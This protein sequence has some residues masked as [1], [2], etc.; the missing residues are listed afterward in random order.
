VLTTVL[1]WLIAVGGALTSVVSF[2]AL[3][4]ILVGKDGA[5]NS[6][7]AG[8]FLVVAVPPLT[9]IAG[10]GLA[11]RWRWAWYG[12]VAGLAGVMLWNAAAMVSHPAP[13][14]TTTVSASGTKT[15]VYREGATFFLPTFVLATGLLVVL[16]IPRVRREFTTARRPSSQATGMPESATHTGFPPGDESAVARGWRVGHEGRDQMYYEERHGGGWQRIDISGEMLMGRA[17]HVIYFPSAKAWERMPEWARLRRDEI[18]ARIKS[19]FRQ[20]DYEYAEDVASSALP[21]GSAAPTRPGSARVMQRCTPQQMRALLAV[22][23]VMLGFAGYM[24]WKVKGGWDNRTVTLPIPKASLQRPVQRD[25][26]PSLFWF[27]LGIYGAA[28]AG[29]LAV[30]G[31]LGVQGWKA[32]RGA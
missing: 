13:T 19:E 18:I 25:L 32:W 2:F 9:A 1:G 3:L 4:M 30:A 16:L 6:D 11:L 10:V 7:V 5:R 26:E 15:T 17:H 21:Q 22:V 28:S 23:V 8:F 24:G 29:S 27:S 31:W 14:V 20:P 12:L